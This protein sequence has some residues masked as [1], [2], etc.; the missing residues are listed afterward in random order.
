MWTDSRTFLSA[1]CN[2]AADDDNDNGNDADNDNDADNLIG[3]ASVRSGVIDFD[4][5]CQPRRRRVGLVLTT[6][7]KKGRANSPSGTTTSKGR[8]AEE[9]F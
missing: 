9:D 1:I 6:R 4:S 3:A 2:D 7:K 5:P 8:M